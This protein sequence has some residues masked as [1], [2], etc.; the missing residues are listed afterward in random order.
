MMVCRFDL[1][2]KCDFMRNFAVIAWL[3]ICLFSPSTIPAAEGLKVGY[4]DVDASP[5][6]GSPMA[7]DKTIEV[8]SP[9]RCRGIVLLGAESPIV[10]CAVDW[11]E[12]ANDGHRAF[13]MGLAEAAGTSVKRVSV[14]VLHQHDAPWCDFSADQI[15]QEQGIQNEMFDSTFARDVIRRAAIAVKEAVEKAESVT[16]VGLGSGIVEEVASN[17]R[18]LGADGKVKAVRYTATTDPALRAAPEG[19]IDPQL[20]SICFWNG[21]RRIVELTYYATHP[22]SYYR[23]GRANPDFPGMARDHRQKVTN[24]PH[25]HFNGAGGNIGAGKYNDGRHELRAILAERVANGMKLAWENE[26]R[27]PVTGNDVKWNFVAVAL[28]PAEHLNESVLSNTLTNKDLANRDRVL[29]A[30]QLAWLQ[31]SRQGPKIDIGCLSIGSARVLHM[32]AE[33]FVEYQLAAQELR[34]DLFVAMAAYGDC[35]PWYIGTEI[36]YQQGGYETAP[37]SSLVASHVEQ[38]LVA[39]MEKL[40]DAP[41]PLGKRLGVEAAEREMELARQAAPT[42]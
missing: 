26:R 22:Q 37:T 17:R 34:P 32:P 5:P 10:L 18:I 20:K 24:V 11:I 23:T 35:G 28:P 12:I 38:V 41:K 3:L 39:A 27:F 4:F 21:E 30:C 36:A 6:I 31:R 33:L 29:A 8:L 40:L 16:H 13:R 7:Y 1:I 25:V 14:H 19:V 15:A 2:G 42:K 9:L